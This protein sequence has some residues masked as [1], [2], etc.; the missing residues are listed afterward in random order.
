M[1]SELRCLHPLVQ[2]CLLLLELLAVPLEGKPT[3]PTQVLLHF[4]FLHAEQHQGTA[5]RTTPGY[6]MQNNTRVLHAEQHQG[7]A[8]RTTPGYCMQ[9]NTR[10]LHA[11]QHQGTACRTTPGYCMQNNTRVLHAE[12]HQGTACR[13]TPGYCMQNNTRVLTRARPPYKLLLTVPGRSKQS[14]CRGFRS[15]ESCLE[16]KCST[17]VHRRQDKKNIHVEQHSHD[18]RDLEMACPFSGTC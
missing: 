14:L 10:V 13:T 12:Q 3:E 18:T 16:I 2:C 17:V 6:C 1:L 11:E 5:C 15:A 8:C 9:N 4:C 7:T